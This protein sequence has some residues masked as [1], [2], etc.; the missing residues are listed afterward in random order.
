MNLFNETAASAVLSECGTYR[1]LLTRTWNPDR[2]PAV[3]IMLNP[4]TADAAQDD[5]TIRRCISFSRGWGR[6]GIV[7][8]NLYAYRA[9]NPRELEKQHSGIEG[10]FGML[11]AIGPENDKYIEQALLNAG[12]VVAGWGST[13]VIG[14][15]DRVV[16]I[17]GL[18]QASGNRLMCL[19]ITQ[20]GHPGHPLYIPSTQPLQTYR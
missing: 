20:A 7:V 8:V 5:P 19:N 2:T 17:R 6:G 13:P 1:Y 14:I 16:T 18:V 3:W 15:A 9:T 12:V 4:S 11:P 10:P